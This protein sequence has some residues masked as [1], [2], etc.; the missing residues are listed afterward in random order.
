M[1]VRFT[2][3]AILLVARPTGAAGAEWI[4]IK[5]PHFIVISDAG[6]RRA[7]DVGWQFEQIRGVLVRVWPGAKADLDK[8]FVVY[9]AKDES[10][11]RALAPRYFEGRNAVRPGS[12]FASAPYGHAVALRA[13]LR[14]E[15]GQGSANPF[16][17]SYWSYVALVLRQSYERDPPPWFLRGLAEF[18]SNTIIRDTEVHIGP[19]IAWH[20]EQLRDSARPTLDVLLDA[21]YRS[22]YLTDGSKM[23]VFDATAWTL[24]HYLMLGNEG[25]NLPL[26]DTFAQAVRRGS[27]PKEAML[28]TYGGAERVRLELAGYITR[29]IFVYQ[30]VGLAVTIDRKSFPMRALAPADAAAALARLHAIMQRPVEAR[31]Q[32]AAA[33]DAGLEVEGFL[34]DAEDKRDAARTAYAKASDAGTAGF[35]AEHRFA[36]LSWPDDHAPDAE[37]RLAAMERGLRRATRLNPRFAP[38]QSLLAETLVRLHRAEEALPF[39]QQS[40]ALASTDPFN[41]LALARTYWALSKRDEAAASARRAL[42]LADTENERRSAQQLVEFLARASAPPAVAGDAAAPRADPNKRFAECEKGDAAACREVLPIALDACG[43]EPRACSAA[44]FLYAEGR[45]VPRDND[46]AIALV[47]KPCGTGVLE[48]CTQLA[49]LLTRRRAQGDLTRAQELL[50]KSCKGGIA[51]ACD[52]LKGLK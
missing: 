45:G 18:F 29:S 2:V 38:A 25:K 42:A 37:A 43:R 7:R 3:L 11:M 28:Q 9:A 46:K 35:Y 48:A 34:L 14:A 1:R 4:E 10:S 39:A 51:A 31:A 26:F 47:E 5:T 12:V 40:V 33:G 21:D 52:L 49:T 27:D 13:D 36:Q 24:I 23:N 19:V 8:D 32:M 17:T 20:L 22:P 15:P 6:E 50:D 30:R 16:R 41:H 44:A